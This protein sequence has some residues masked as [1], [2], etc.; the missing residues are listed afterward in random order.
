MVRPGTPRRCE[1][2]LH[3]HGWLHSDPLP[4]LPALTLTRTQ[5]L[6]LPASCQQAVS[7]LQPTRGAGKRL[8]AG[9]REKP[10]HFSHQSCSRGRVSGVSPPCPSPHP[11]VYLGSWHV[12][13]S[14]APSSWG[15]EWFPVIASVRLSDIS[16]LT[17]PSAPHIWFLLPTSVWIVFLMHPERHRRVRQYMGLK[18]IILWEKLAE[19]D[20]QG[21]SS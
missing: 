17:V 19:E 13:S 11:E 10:G 2:E 4:N 14:P 18:N 1:H 9:R 16:V 12:A 3:T 15:T 21:N 7:K 8:E 6:H 20:I 5:N